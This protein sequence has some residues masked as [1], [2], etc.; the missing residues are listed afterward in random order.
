MTAPAVYLAVR[1]AR[2]AKSSC[3]SSASSSP[4][5][6][7]RESSGRELRH[8]RGRA[9]RRASRR[10]R[11]AH[12]AHQGHGRLAPDARSAA[13]PPRPVLGADTEVVLDGR[14]FGKPADASARRTHAGAALPGARIDVLTAVALRWERRHPWPRSPR[15]SVTLRELDRRRDRALRRHRASQFDKA[16][17]LRDPGTAPRP[18][19][20][21]DRTAAIPA[22]WACPCTRPAAARPLAGHQAVPPC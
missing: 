7:L 4:A 2:A 10:L 17:A 16:G 15:R 21:R 18:F 12:R 1:R 9:R 5:L 19:V 8:R 6:R 13:L 20:H 14:I 3:A 22:S 11:R